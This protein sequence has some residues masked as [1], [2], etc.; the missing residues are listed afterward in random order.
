[1][2]PQTQSN[3]RPSTPT[4][5]IRGPEANT[6]KKTRFYDLYDEKKPA[7]LRN[8]DIAE[9]SEISISTIER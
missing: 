9:L 2:A 7:G 3:D 8:V 4:R 5:A 6:I 1:M